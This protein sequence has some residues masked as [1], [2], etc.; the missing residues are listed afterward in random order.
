MAHL[1]GKVSGMGAQAKMNAVGVWI[2]EPNPA[3]GGAPSHKLGRELESAITPPQPLSESQL[4]LLA[5]A[6]HEDYR[7]LP[8]T[9]DMAVVIDA[10]ECDMA[11]IDELVGWHHDPT[12]DDEKGGLKGGRG[13]ISARGTQG[14][15]AL[16]L[17]CAY[18][19]VYASTGFRDRAQALTG[20]IVQSISKNRNDAVQG[21]P[22]EGQSGPSHADEKLEK[23]VLLITATQ[24]ELEEEAE[25]IELQKPMIVEPEM[26]GRLGVESTKSSRDCG[27]TAPFSM[28]LRHRFQ[29]EPHREEDNHSETRS[30]CACSLVFF[31]E[32]ERQT[33]LQSILSRDQKLRR[34]NY[35]VFP[36][37]DDGGKGGGYDL[38]RLCEKFADAW[39]WRH[40]FRSYNPLR[41]MQLGVEVDLDTVQAYFGVEIAFYFHF[42]ALLAKWL[43]FPA[44]VGAAFEVAYFVLTGEG[45]E[46]DGLNSE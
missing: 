36:L 26:W 33:L 4:P 1:S 38:K 35:H 16:G 23:H 8:L 11:D 39:G 28:A 18:Y 29:R 24:K 32:C 5:R 20:G 9:Y 27:V 41:S 25:M 13:F 40:F 15:H 17:E 10:H 44:V 21:D 14:L 6:R 45:Q 30:A 7:E 2:C 19:A 37:H 43:F 12:A 22:M 3:S 46:R 42:V 31:S 34:L